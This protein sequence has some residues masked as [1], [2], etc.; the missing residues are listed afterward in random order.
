MRS[1]RDCGSSRLAAD[2]VISCFCT[3]ASLD[4]ATFAGLSANL[5]DCI[6]GAGLCPNH[7]VFDDSDYCVGPDRL[8][9]NLPRR[10]ARGK[11]AAR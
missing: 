5:S 10:V 7:R 2:I 9:R 1:S 11:E 4:V 6:D 8:C 3:G